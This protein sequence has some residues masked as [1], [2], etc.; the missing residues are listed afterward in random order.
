MKLPAPEL[1]RMHV[2]NQGPNGFGLVERRGPAPV[3]VAAE[4]GVEQ[5]RANADYSCV[6]A[7]LDKLEGFHWDLL[8][9]PFFQ[10]PVLHRGGLERTF[11]SAS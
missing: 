10:L 4:Y 2:R 8:A 3:A 1:P 5:D 7:Q 9:K 11:E 6:R